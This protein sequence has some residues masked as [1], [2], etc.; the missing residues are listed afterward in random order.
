MRR[1]PIDISGMN[2]APHRYVYWKFWRIPREAR[3]AW[4]HFIMTHPMGGYAAYDDETMRVHIKGESFDTPSR[5]L[6]ELDTLQRMRDA[7]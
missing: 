4:L 5:A 3:H 2:S 7:L 6:S 1:H